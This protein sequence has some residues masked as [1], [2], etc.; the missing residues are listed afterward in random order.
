MPRVRVRRVLLL[1]SV[2]LL[3]ATTAAAEKYYLVPFGSAHRTR[4]PWR[5]HTFVTA[6]RATS[7]P[8]APDGCRLDTHTVSW[9]PAG[10]A[11]LPNLVTPGPGVNLDLPDTLKQ[12]AADGQRVSVWGPYEV[13]AET[14]AAVK[15]QADAL[16]AGGRNYLGF[17]FLAGG[18]DTN[19]VRAAA[20]G[21]GAGGPFPFPLT[22][23]AAAQAVAARLVR[24]GAV[25]DPAADHT[26]LLDRLGVGGLDYSHEEYRPGPFGIDW[27]W[28]L[29]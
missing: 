7:D 13:R 6:V 25:L 17:A 4:L 22:G 29:R 20:A 23:K 28:R 1:A 14:F 12:V 27:T 3:P 9:F 2:V 21:T 5:S 8:A 15:A 10:F 26:G 16:D 18:D 11:V 19:C 24:S